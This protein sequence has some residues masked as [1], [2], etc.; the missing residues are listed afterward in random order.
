MSLRKPHAAFA[1]RREAQKA[2]V[3]VS[4]WEPHPLQIHT[5]SEFCPLQQQRALE[6]IKGHLGKELTEELDVG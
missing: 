4:R 2:R 1:R 3:I 6:T 5:I